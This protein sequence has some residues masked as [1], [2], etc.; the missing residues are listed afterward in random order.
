MKAKARIYFEES[1]LMDAS[2]MAATFW[3]ALL[4]FVIADRVFHA[5]IGQWWIIIYP[6]VG[7]PLA[8]IIKKLAWRKRIKAFMERREARKR[9]IATIDYLAQTRVPQ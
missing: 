3:I 8:S 4:V 2:E 9:L 1:F 5:N 6:V 7:A